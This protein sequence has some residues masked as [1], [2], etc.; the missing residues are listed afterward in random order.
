MQCKGFRG[1]CPYDELYYYLV[2]SVLFSVLLAIQ[3]VLAQL[4]GKAVFLTIIIGNFIS[5]TLASNGQNNRE[6][7]F[8][9]LNKATQINEWDGIIN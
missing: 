4:L 2:Y 8:I 6:T 9:H 3:S 5:V 7:C 1:L